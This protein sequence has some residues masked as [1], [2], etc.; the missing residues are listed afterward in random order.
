MF[1]HWQKRLWIVAFF[2]GL[3][4]VLGSY[5]LMEVRADLPKPLAS[6]LFHWGTTPRQV[7]S[8]D[9]VVHPKT[10]VPD[11]A[12]KPLLLELNKYRST[13]NLEP[14]K[15]DPKLT[16]VAEELLAGMAESGYDSNYELDNAELEKALKNSGYNYERVSHN[17]LSGPKTID[18]VMVAWFSD[19][20][21]VEALDSSE[22]TDIGMATIISDTKENGQIGVVVQLLGKQRVAN[23]TNQQVTQN[24]T[25]IPEAREV[26][27]EEVIIA[28]NRYRE[29]HGLYKLQV[30][31]LLC[32][33]AEK[34]ALDLKAA[35]GLDGHAGFQ[36]DFAHQDNLPVGIKDYPKGSKFTENLAHQFCKNMTTGESFV[37]QTGTALIEWCFDSSTKGHREAQLST[38]S[39]NVCVRHADN[40]YVVIFGT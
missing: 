9:D 20:D 7:T 29:A 32:Q 25:E 35:G 4:I 3:N 23:S 22:F 16:K 1:R 6:L 11:L 38:E 36:Q 40:M 34:R 31:P 14:L 2:I 13:Q 10:E 30:N 18:A 33:Y 27:D 17:S 15:S 39:I 5:F 37:A 28:L 21:Q 12:V 8:V 19:A 24:K 26:S